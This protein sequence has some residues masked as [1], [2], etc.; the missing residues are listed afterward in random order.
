MCE[1]DDMYH[2]VICYF[3]YLYLC[4]EAQ[5]IEWFVKLEVSFSRQRAARL[6]NEGSLGRIRMPVLGKARLRRS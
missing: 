6:R 2:W 5:N 4:S 1:V 3:L